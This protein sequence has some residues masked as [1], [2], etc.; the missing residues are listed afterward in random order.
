[1][2]IISVAPMPSTM[3]DAGRLAPGVPGRGGQMLAGRDAGAQGGEMSCSA[4]IGIIAL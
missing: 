1:M 3:R 4:S 2:C